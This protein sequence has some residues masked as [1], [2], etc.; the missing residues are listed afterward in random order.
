MRSLTKFAA[1]SAV[2]AALAA[3]GSS[4]EVVASPTGE[5]PSEATSA[6]QDPEAAQR[7]LAAAVDT[8]REEA[9]TQFGFDFRIGGVSFADIQGVD[10]EPPGGW[11]ATAKL[12]N[13]DGPDQDEYVMHVR[14]AKGSVWMQMESWP[15]EQRGCWLGMTATQAPLGYAAM[16]PDEPVY[17]QVPGSLRARGFVDADKTSI[18]GDL[19]LAAALG[20]LNAKTLTELAIT[21]PAVTDRWVPVSIELGDERVTAVLLSGPD[22][23]ATLD[24]AGIGVGAAVRPAI[25]QFQI[26]LS[27]AAG[28]AEVIRPPAAKLVSEE[29]TGCRS[30]SGGDG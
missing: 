17:L 25:R 9:V 7:A 22:L 20:L 26:R 16:R 15:A 10:L 2:V 23:L 19:D 1:A 27:Y 18:V 3:C 21:E 8:I 12:A 30:G 29:G 5:A 11:R 28:T 6:P 13:V 14:S 4:P 24:E